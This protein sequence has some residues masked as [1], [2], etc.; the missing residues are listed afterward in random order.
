VKLLKKLISI[1]KLAIKLDNKQET[2]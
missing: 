2:A 1:L